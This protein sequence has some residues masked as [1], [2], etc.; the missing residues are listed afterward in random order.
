MLVKMLLLAEGLVELEFFF[1]ML[2]GGFEIEKTGFERAADGSSLV[3][4]HPV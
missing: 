4:Q 3:V 2:E 1:E